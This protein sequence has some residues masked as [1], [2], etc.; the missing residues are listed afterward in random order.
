MRG[1]ERMT[2]ANMR[3]HGV[4]SVIAACVNCGR[5]TDVNV[6]LLPETLIVPEVGKRLRCSSCGGNTISARPLGI[7]A[8]GR[9]FL[10]IGPNARRCPRLRRPP[11]ARLLQTGT[12]T[13]QTSTA[14]IT[15]VIFSLV[16]RSMASSG[17]D[18]NLNA[19][20]YAAW[21]FTL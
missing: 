12:G 5:S 11:P 8:N 20:L 1:F 17:S 18:A 19:A 2:L 4:R 3:L 21:V 16:D 9:G 15:A 14:A 6:D 13:A 10:T 7:Q